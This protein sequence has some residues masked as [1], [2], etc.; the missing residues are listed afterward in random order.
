M[1]T[2]ITYHNHKSSH[3]IKI[4]IPITSITYMILKASLKIKIKK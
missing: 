2:Q 4:T 3:I 1:H